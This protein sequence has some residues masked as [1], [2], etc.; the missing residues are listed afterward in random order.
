VPDA[1]NGLFQKP[2]KVARGSWGEGEESYG[3]L[4][5]L[6][7][8]RLFRNSEMRALWIFNPKAGVFWSFDDPYSLSVKMDYVKQKGLGGVMFGN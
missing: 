7:G 4:R 2:S 6:K 1:N 3:N 5:S 8:F